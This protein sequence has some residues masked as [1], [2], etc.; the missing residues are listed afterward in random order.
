[1]KK[2]KNVVIVVLIAMCAFINMPIAFAASC[3]VVLDGPSSVNVGEEIEL[4]VAVKDIDGYDGLAGFDGK[5]IYDTDYLEYISYSKIVGFGTMKYSDKN[6]MMIGFAG[7]IDEWTKGP[8]ANLI[9]FTFKA[10]QIGN[11]VVMID[12]PGPVA[13]TPKA[14]LIP[15]TTIPK[16]ITIN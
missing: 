15:A 14:P 6:N 9:K 1:M 4:I 10:K 13:A 3:K 12:D 11:T 16:T 5:L 7:D 2:L 8:D